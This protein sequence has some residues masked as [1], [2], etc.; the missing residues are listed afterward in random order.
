MPAVFQ[1]LSSRA[2]RGCVYRG[3]IA[4]GRLAITQISTPHDHAMKTQGA[5]K[6]KAF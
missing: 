1:P 6:E 4:C 2:N 5:Q 3:T